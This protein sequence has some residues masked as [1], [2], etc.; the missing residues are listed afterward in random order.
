MR[1][2][3]LVA[4]LWLVTS[5]LWGKI[6]FH[7]KRDGNHEIY[8]M[9]SDGSDQTRLTFNESK[10]VAPVWS[11][12]GRQIAFHSSRHDDN[13]PHTAEEN[14][15][16]YVMDAD[17]SNQRRLTHYPGL[18]GYA[19]WHPD[20]SQI[21]FDS[22]R[23]GNFNIYVMDTDGSN[24]KQV[25]DLE[26]ASRPRWSP[27]GK[28]IAFEG[29]MG[30]NQRNIYVI[31][32]NGTAPFRVSKPRPKAHMFLGD[33]SPDGKQILYKETVNAN[34]ANS[35]AV[36]A[37]LNLVGQRKVKHWDRLPVPRMPFHSTAFSADGKSILFAGKR[38][39]AASDI[40][41]FHLADRKLIQLTDSPGP[42]VAAH[43]WNPRLSV[44]PQ[45]LLPLFW[46]EIKSDLLRH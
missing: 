23:D 27:D 45:R 21:A 42:D 38:N 11:P 3:I 20:G 16:I 28:R 32:A 36:I 39:N 22:T 30:G 34:L 14:M 10:D 40:Y 19:D 25:T 44:R 29:Y 35:F 13:D 4:C 24:V 41:R 37:T 15:E 31:S 46:G 17:G 18:D 12:N 9:D 6:A 5:P 26:F 43:E 8:T 1:M 33:W 2:T 7:S